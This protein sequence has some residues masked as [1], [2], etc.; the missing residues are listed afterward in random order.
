MK[1][2]Y[3]KPLIEEVLTDSTD[4]IASSIDALA[5]IDYIDI[6]TDDT[7]TLGIGEGYSRLDDIDWN[8]AL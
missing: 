3:I 5:D 8:N 7:E 2:Q 6:T 1:K 4:I